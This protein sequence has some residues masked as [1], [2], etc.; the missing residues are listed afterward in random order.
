MNKSISSRLFTVLFVLLIGCNPSPE[1]KELQTKISKASETIEQESAD[2]KKIKSEI[3]KKQKEYEKKMD[4]LCNLASDELKDFVKNHGKM[5]Q[6]IKE[7]SKELSVIS[8]EVG[9]LPKR[10]D[11]NMR[12]STELIKE[13]F[14]LHEKRAGEIVKDADKIERKHKKYDKKISQLMASSQGQTNQGEQ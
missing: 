11:E 13:D 4:E 1:M 10:L 7:L 6:E 8:V 3:S 12:F 2:V 9:E 5:T 14:E